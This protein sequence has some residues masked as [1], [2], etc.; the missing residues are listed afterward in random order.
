M[1]GGTVARSAGRSLLVVGAWLGLSQSALAHP[2]G[3]AQCS[4]RL[5]FESGRPQRLQAELLLD[6]A[7]S[8]EAWAVIHD[9]ATGEMR[10]GM[11]QRFAFGLRMQMGRFNWMY[12]LEADGA[13]V[14]LHA[15]LDPQLSFEHGRMRIRVSFDIPGAPAAAD[16]WSLH[17]A[18]PTYYWV[19]AFGQTV[20]VARG[21]M[22]ASETDPAQTAA[23][24]A[25]LPAATQ[26]PAAV[27]LFG[28]V[29]R[30][31]AAAE[32]VRPGQARID[33]RC[34]P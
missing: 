6:R 21:P 3:A 32:P 33:W 2:H 17:C 4:A 29:R 20:D 23:R 1:R 24:L 19:T 7:H 28:C 30:P 5:D 15:P 25:A 16:R 31:A 34:A 12:R 11:L 9:A 13:D 10:P 22:L 26:D 27:E 14:A 8:Q 18:D